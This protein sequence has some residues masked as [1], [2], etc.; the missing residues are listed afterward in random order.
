MPKAWPSMAAFS[1]ALSKSSNESTRPPPIVARETPVFADATA[2]RASCSSEKVAKDF[3]FF[4]SSFW[5]LAIILKSTP[6]LFANF[7]PALTATAS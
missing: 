3:V 2:T 6:E 4:L 1:A 5:D 7:W